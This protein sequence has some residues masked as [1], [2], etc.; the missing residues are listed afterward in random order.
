MT[1][2]K[3]LG[4][5]GEAHAC[6][7][8]KSAKFTDIVPLN[9]GRQHPGGDVMAKRD[10]RVYFFSVKARDRFGQDRKPKPGYN[11][12][13]AFGRSRGRIGLL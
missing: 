1:Y 8:L 13:P 10:G 5:W 7:L 3:I 6:R 11:I 12:Y 2:R 4:D 9:V